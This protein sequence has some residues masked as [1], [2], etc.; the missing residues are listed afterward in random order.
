[1]SADLDFPVERDRGE[2]EELAACRR[3]DPEMFY[4]PD[5]ARGPFRRAWEAKAK[6]VCRACPVIME[7]REY[8]LEAKER[9]GVWGG[10]SEEDR[11]FGHAAPVPMASHPEPAVGTFLESDLEHSPGEPVTV[12]TPDVSTPTSTREHHLTT[13][14]TIP[15]FR[16]VHLEIEDIADLR[17]HL[18]SE[19]HGL[20][21][22]DVQD[23]DRQELLRLHREDHAEQQSLNDPT[24]PC[25]GRDAADCDCA[26]R[27]R[28]ELIEEPPTREELQ[29]PV[30]RVELLRVGD[31]Q[32][33]PAYQRELNE[34]RI[35]K[36]K[37][38]FKPIQLGIIE[39]SRRDDGTMFVVDGQHR[40][41]L[42]KQLFG[43]NAQ[44]PAQ[45]YEGWSLQQEAERFG[46][47]NKERVQVTPLAAY[48]A[49]RAKGAE[50]V[51]IIDRTLSAVHVRVSEQA[52]DGTVQ[53]VT[54]LRSAVA[55]YG[56]NGLWNGVH[57]IHAVWGPVRDA[58]RTSIVASACWVLH[59]YGTAIDLAILTESLK[60]QYYSALTLYKRAQSRRDEHGGDVTLNVSTIMVETY[61]S[62]VPAKR[63]VPLP[64]DVRP[65]ASKRVNDQ[66]RLEELQRDARDAARRA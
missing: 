31:L 23:E 49:D 36:Y 38:D 51:R 15:G 16:E 1:M 24:V 10:M 59:T 42:V 50:D 6:A 53:C 34:R 44:L 7:C 60:Q 63:R 5:N 8:A 17:G 66:R 37:V 13:A 20:R 14:P 30:L 27:D 58:Y 25:C 29:A 45:V 55:R 18:Q 19:H 21:W 33:D 22:S 65:T 43:P 9:F 39:V 11:G 57:L 52:G 12:F 47:V 56:E 48:K 4:L 28:G 41:A 40:V 61:N 64:A 2:W 32:V 54:E 3:A 62:A 46:Y 35:R 26:H